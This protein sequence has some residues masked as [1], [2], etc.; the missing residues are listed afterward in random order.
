MN[1]R[2]ILEYKHL[3]LMPL[4]VHL[5]NEEMMWVVYKQRSLNFATKC[6]ISW[7]ILQVYSFIYSLVIY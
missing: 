5:A 2:K 7:L 1:W 4:A 6:E 3:V